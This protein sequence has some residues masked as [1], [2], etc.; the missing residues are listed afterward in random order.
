[1]RSI[2]PV[3]GGRSPLSLAGNHWPVTEFISAL[4]GALAGVVFGTVFERHRER[5]RMVYQFYER[6]ILDAEFRKVS[7]NVGTIA[8]AWRSG[9]RA[10]L[11]H[12]V[13]FPNAPAEKPCENN[14][15]SPHVNFSMALHFWAAIH[16][17]LKEGLLD[18]SLLRRLMGHHFCWYDDVFGDFVAQYQERVAKHPDSQRPTPVW[19]TAIPELRIFFVA[20]KRIGPENFWTAV[21]DR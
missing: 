21:Y 19:V 13:R 4:I 17:Y 6:F 20:G 16:A 14:Q 1:V 5:R 8:R 18:E 15:L 2:I 10:V 11:D 3:S 12:F 9:D 7:M